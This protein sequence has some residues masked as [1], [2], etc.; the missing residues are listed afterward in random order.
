MAE[1]VETPMGEMTV[2]TVEELEAQMDRRREKY[3]RQADGSYTCRKCGAAIRA[4]DVAH[5]IWDGPFAMSGSGQC[6]NEQRPY[7]PKCEKAPSF[8][9]DPVAPKGSYHN[10]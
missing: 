6:F 4:V 7:C 5:P 9:G 3:I 1:K 8:R 2:L 10:P